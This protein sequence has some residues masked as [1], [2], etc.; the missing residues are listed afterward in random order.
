MNTELVRRENNKAFT[1]SL[2]IAENC[3]LQHK[4]V[5]GLIRKHSSYFEEHGQVAFQTRLNSQGSPTDFCNLN[6]D[7][8]TFLITLFRNTE[9]VLRFKSR[10]VKEFRKALDEINRLY[11]NPPRTDLL[12][13][14]RQ[15]HNP[16]MTALIEMR[17]DLNK[18]TKP[19]HFMCENKLC[20]G[21]VTGNYSKADETE[22]S[23]SDIELLALVRKRNEALLVAGIP[24]DERKK[25]LIAFATKHRTKLI[26]CATTK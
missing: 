14:K 7:Q 10:L 2:V 4:N 22:L 6:E 5:I 11:A 23:N 9:I 1:T 24:Y 25:R 19:V 8:A 20:N 21:V 18:E 12:K 3:K 16:M 13:D 15:S 26:E 17:E